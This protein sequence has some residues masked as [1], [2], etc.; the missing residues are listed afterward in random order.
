M[1][2][3]DSR[4]QH[5]KQTLYQLS[6]IREGAEYSR[7]LRAAQLFAEQRHY[8]VR[9]RIPAEHRLREDEL[10]VDVHVED[11]VIARDDLDGA[12][13]VLPLLEDPRR[14]TGGVRER[15]SGDAV[16]DADVVTFRHHGDSVRPKRRAPR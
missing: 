15:S 14:Q 9:L 16:L 6:Y 3:E 11:P 4:D 1:T 7:G 2:G 12:D 8:V 13:R 5:G 10:P